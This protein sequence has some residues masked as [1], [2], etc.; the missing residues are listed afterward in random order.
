MGGS[1]IAPRRVGATAVQ[2]VTVHLDQELLRRA[3]KRTGKGVTAT[4][5][6]GLP[7]LAVSDAYDRL[8]AGPGKVQFAIDLEGLRSD[9]R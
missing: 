8:R 6:E 4:I 3:R 2:K 7:L 1:G 5:R 9:R